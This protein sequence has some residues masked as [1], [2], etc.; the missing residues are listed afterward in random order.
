LWRQGEIFVEFV[1]FI[2][3]FRIGLAKLVTG[4]AL[5]WPPVRLSQLLLSWVLVTG[6]SAFVELVRGVMSCFGSR[7]ACAAFC[8]SSA[9]A[10]AG[11][12]FLAFACFCFG[13]WQGKGFVE[14][15]RLNFLCLAFLLGLR[16]FLLELHLFSESPPVPVGL[17]HFVCYVLRKHVGYFGTF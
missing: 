8:W 12:S 5:S 13:R 9:I 4:F 10:I 3:S 15:V 14:V 16:V 11:V 2:F 6:E 17:S 1:R 7:R